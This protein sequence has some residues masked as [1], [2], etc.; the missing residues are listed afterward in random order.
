MVKILTQNVK[1]LN[2]KSKRRGFFIYAKQKADIICLQETHSS[3]TSENFFDW[4]KEWGNKAH[5]SHANTRERG[6]GILIKKNSEIE[7]KK[8]FS[9]NNG[10]VIGITYM[11]KNE[12]FTLIN[13]Y[14]P[15][16]DNP[17]FWVEVF[18]YFEDNPGKR[19][20]VGD[21]NVALNTQI[22]RSDAKASNNDKSKEIINKYM[23]DTLLTDVWR[24]RNPHDRTFTYCRLK[25]YFIGSRI[26][27]IL[28]DLSISGWTD[29][30]RIIP[31]FRSDHSA[32]IIKLTPH[33]V[34]R[35][36][37]LWKLNTQVLYESEY[38]T[39]I[40][41]T[42]ERTKS[43]SEKRKLSKADTWEMLKLNVIADSQSYCTERAL[44]RKM[45]INQ[46]ETKIAKYEQDIQD[47]NDSE[48]KLYQKTKTDYQAYMDEI[49]QGAIFRSGC[50]YYNEGEKSTK[51]FFSLEK[52]RSGAKQMNCLISETGEQIYEP[53]QILRAQHDFF[54]K[55]YTKRENV[56]FNY[57]NTSGITVDNEQKLQMEGLILMHEITNAIKEMRRGKAPGCDG[58]PI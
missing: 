45:I 46:L 18:K 38:I 12:T 33:S 5:W 9:D 57:K 29:E 55:L 27:Y 7:I 25:P 22:D 37:G 34:D 10:R 4:D 3:D 36:R 52:Y 53:E 21:F 32:M 47:L 11:Y 17:K 14:A 6:V 24:D 35:G 16:D 19:I 48:V 51:Y 13:V 31:G 28:T 23:E 39:M 41:Q 30:V 8:E 49:A 15:N 42:I 20:L 44:N 58:L 2:E 40:N 43:C 54:K 50:T 1:G 26:D 56:T